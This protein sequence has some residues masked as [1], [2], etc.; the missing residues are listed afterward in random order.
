MPGPLGLPTGAIMAHAA[1]RSGLSSASC[2]GLAG[3]RVNTRFSARHSPQL[4]LA[5]SSF[6]DMQSSLGQAV[7]SIVRSPVRSTVRRL[8]IHAFKGADDNGEPL[9]CVSLC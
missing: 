7:H 5:R 6:L 9:L 8:G 4:A 2:T 1:Q 3:L